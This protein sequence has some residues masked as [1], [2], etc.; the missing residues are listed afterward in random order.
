MLAVSILASMMHIYM[1]MHITVKVLCCGQALW[2]LAAVIAA[3]PASDMKH[4]LHSM[5]ECAVQRVIVQRGV[6]CTCLAVNEKSAAH[7]K[8]FQELT[9]SCSASFSQDT[10]AQGSGTQLC[11][12]I[13]RC[14][15]S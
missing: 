13:H 14:P 3:P 12:H 11:M 4:T 2:H 10:G 1:Y 6:L 9:G 7:E 15:H 5:F 8:V